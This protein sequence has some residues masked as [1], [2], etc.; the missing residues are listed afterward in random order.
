[1]QAAGLQPLF[2]LSD[3]SQLLTVLVL[4]HQSVKELCILLQLTF[5][6]ETGSSETEA[7]NS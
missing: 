2:M 1:M 3:E 6:D 4:L 5:S 7:R